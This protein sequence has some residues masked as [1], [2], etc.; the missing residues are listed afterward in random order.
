MVTGVGMDMAKHVAAVWS[1]VPGAPPITGEHDTLQAESM[2]I[3]PA[4]TC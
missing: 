4:G 2:P 1:S 3:S